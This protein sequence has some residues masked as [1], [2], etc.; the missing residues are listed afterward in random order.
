MFI[1]PAEER[2]AYSIHLQP[3]LIASLVLFSAGIVAGLVIVDRI[4]LLA[5]HF[6]ETLGRFIK[7]F[8]ELPRLKLAAAIFLNNGAKTLVAIVLGA[9][10]G[11]VPA[12]FLLANGV[13]L[14]VAMS[15]SVSTR[16]VWLSILSIA[17][18]GIFE[19]PAVFLGTSIGLMLGLRTIVGLRRQ[20]QTSLKHELICA[21]RYYCTVI[22]PLLLVAALVEAF[23]TSALVAPR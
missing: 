20:S 9:G 4:P 17:P 10:L 18:H 7:T 3:Y 12:I 22:L 11:I 23:V 13:A 6:A 5:D 15:L 1:L 8:V 19:L 21:L 2:R 16:G 14:A